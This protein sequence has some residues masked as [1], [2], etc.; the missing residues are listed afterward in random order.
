MYNDLFDLLIDR[1]RLSEL[2]EA[3]VGTDGY[4]LKIL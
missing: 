3:T 2:F 1:Q 4:F